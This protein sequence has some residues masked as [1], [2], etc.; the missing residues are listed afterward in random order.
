VIPLLSVSTVSS[1][2]WLFAWLGAAFQDV[3][4][5]RGEL[6]SLVD[7]PT[8]EERRKA[9]SELAARK[10]LTTG[11]LIEAMR[12]FRPHEEAKPGIH[13]VTVPLRVNDATEETEI[14]LY[15]PPSYA[16]D[17]SAPLLLMGH[18]TG[19]SGREQHRLWQAV[20]DSLGMLVV[21]PSEAG[22]N[23]GYA[24]SDRE[25]ASA[26]A[27]LRWCRRRFNVDESRVYA[28]GISRGGHL[29]WDLALRYPDL[30]A[31][32]APMIGGPWLGLGT[33]QNLRYLENVASLPIRD[34]Q[35]SQD[36]PGLVLNVRIAFEKLKAA[37]ARDAAL[38]EFPELGHWFRFGAVDWMEFLGHSVRSPIPQQVVRR[39][40]RRGE[41]R[42]FWVEV[43]ETGKAIQEEFTPQIA[44]EKWEALDDAGRRRWMND[45]AEK[46]TAR[47]EV[48]QTGPGAF[49][50]KG[51]GVE[52]F[53]LLLAEGMFDPKTPVTVH[54][55]GKRHSRKVSAD[56]TVLLPEFAERFDRT[57]LPV[58][59]VRVP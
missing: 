43:L 31:A 34:L 6:S 44:K 46:R 45:E 29:A 3:E 42:A 55:N 17:R 5:L 26:L 48:R 18:G 7:L 41:G 28:S 37:K 57:F 8:V 54:F 47:L 38:H 51:A 21:S 14:H 15:V 10:E 32:I 9:A 12:S 39:C 23:D 11:A 13:A 53:R 25:R 40:A 24:F 22:K 19:G 49:V 1:R 2:A 35:G 20:A 30:F 4:R 36:D 16:R 50:A 33:G 58:A 27:T 56:K 52:S 59:E